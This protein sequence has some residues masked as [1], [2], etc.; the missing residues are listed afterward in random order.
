V[1][2]AALFLPLLTPITKLIN[3]IFKDKNATQRTQINVKELDN[4]VIK[5]FPTE[6][7]ML[8]R[9]QVVEMF[10]YT[11]EMF[12]TIGAY[13]EKPS[14]DDSQY[15]RDIEVSIDTIDRNLNDYLMLA[16][17]GELSPDDMITFTQTLKACKDI[18]RIG[19]Y[20]ENLIDFY[21]PDTDRKINLKDSKNYDIYVKTHALALE[22]IE[23][24]LNVFE[25]S[26][27][28]QAIEVIQT[29]RDEINEIDKLINEHFDV[30]TVDKV[31][32]TSYIDYVFV[33]IMNSYQRVLSHCSNIA[34][35]FGNDKVYVYTK[36]EEE[37]FNK[38]KDRY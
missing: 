9:G 33:D 7:I 23:K 35:L 36:G 32:S 31:N 22:L 25:K 1:T 27:K 29:R 28:T 18:E 20:G 5:Q 10:K 13:L 6:G 38:M 17:K 19:D 37:H 11:V 16:D 14:N 34:K 4:K 3:L 8:A 21:A 2:T 26:D 12:K 30:V 15:V 24:T